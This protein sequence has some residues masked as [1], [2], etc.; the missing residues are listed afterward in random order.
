MT[1]TGLER[2]AR[3]WVLENLPQFPWV[4][5]RLIA[6][7]SAPPEAVDLK[8]VR[9][10]IRR[11]PSI[12]SELLRRA[13]TAAYATLVRV[14]SIDHALHVL[15][16]QAVRR[17]IL[18]VQLRQYLRRALSTA[19]LRRCWEHA[20]A[21]AISAELV[22]HYV[23]IRP[24]QA[25][26]AGLLH[27][28][29]RF[30]MLVNYP[31]SYGELLALSSEHDHLLEAE[32]ALFELDHCQLGA[33]LALEWNFPRELID[34]IALHHNPPPGEPFNL[35]RLASI[36]CSLASLMG[37]G[38]A[39]MRGLQLE[40]VRSQL[41]EPAFWLLEPGIESFRARVLEQMMAYA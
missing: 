19:V 12:A 1:T 21:A 11:D 29:G 23:R 15:G 40:D 16:L 26:T 32:R 36:C 28:L 2:Y 20:L 37:F 33:C 18:T 30:A 5:A 14:S 17:L 31:R 35:L 10:L 25:Y 22:S 24:D 6:L 39:W 34:V 8:Q 13:N 27:D 38:T 9:E 4:L 7:F 41:P 3:P